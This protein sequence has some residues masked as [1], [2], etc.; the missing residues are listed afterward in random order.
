M[1][2]HKRFLEIL[3][4]DAVQPTDLEIITPANFKTPG[5]AKLNKATVGQPHPLAPNS[6][7]LISITGAQIGFVAASNLIESPYNMTYWIE[8]Q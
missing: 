3:Y 6:N 4:T 8:E 5:L 1:S 2:K 7:P